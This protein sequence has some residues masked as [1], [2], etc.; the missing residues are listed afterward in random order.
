MYSWDFEIRIFHFVFKVYK[1]SY[2]YRFSCYYAPKIRPFLFGS[3]YENYAKNADNDLKYLVRPPCVFFSSSLSV[4]KHEGS[5][6]HFR[7]T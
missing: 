4:K 7:E 5:K 3:Y 2:G 1:F 6:L